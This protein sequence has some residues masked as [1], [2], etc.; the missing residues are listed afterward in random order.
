MFF[1]VLQGTKSQLQADVHEIK[2][3]ELSKFELPNK[4]KNP[5]QEVDSFKKMTPAERRQLELNFYETFVGICNEEKIADCEHKDVKFLA[6]LLAKGDSDCIMTCS[7]YQMLQNLDNL[8]NGVKTVKFIQAIGVFLKDLDISK[9]TDK[10]KLTE[11][12]R[13]GCAAV[14]GSEC[15]EKRLI[16]I[17]T[18]IVL[19]TVAKVGLLAAQSH[20]AATSDSE[21]T[22]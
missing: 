18:A 10:N 17:F 6:G 21:F 4:P 16:G 2:N 20:I 1:S 15:A 22:Q 11:M 13:K 12:N 3:E 5:V 14:G 7:K 19:F 9:K 8:P